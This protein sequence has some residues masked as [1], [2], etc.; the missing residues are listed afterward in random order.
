MKLRESDPARNADD[1]VGRVSMN[2]LQPPTIGVGRPFFYTTLTR[3]HP[4]LVKAWNPPRHRAAQKSA[5][6]AKEAKA[7]AEPTASQAFRDVGKGGGGVGGGGGVRRWVGLGG[8]RRQGLASSL[9]NDIP[10]SHRSLAEAQ[11]QQPKQTIQCIL[12]MECLAQ[13]K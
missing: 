12:D 3:Q 8:G 11:P 2:R 10:L 9:V 1:V 7:N 13:E 5:Q 6:A 4:L